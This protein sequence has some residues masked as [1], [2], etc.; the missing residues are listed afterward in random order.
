MPSGAS[1]EEMKTCFER[2][3]QVDKI[4]YSSRDTMWVTFKMY[5]SALRAM[6][7]LNKKPVPL[8]GFPTL[9]GHQFKLSLNDI[10]RRE[11]LDKGLPTSATELNRRTSGTAPQSQPPE[12]GTGGRPGGGHPNQRPSPL[13]PVPV[14]KHRTSIQQPGKAASSVR[15]QGGAPMGAGAKSTAVTRTPPNVSRSPQVPPSRKTATPPPPPKSTAPPPPSQPPP[16]NSARVGTTASK[17]A[18]ASRQQPKTQ[19]A[20]KAVPSSKQQPKSQEASQV[21]PSPLQQPKKQEASEGDLQTGRRVTLRLQ[22]K[23]KEKVTA[24]AEEGVTTEAS[25]SAVSPKASPAD[26]SSNPNSSVAATLT[27]RGGVSSGIRSKAPPPCTQKKTLPE[28]AQTTQCLQGN[29]TEPKQPKPVL[30][31]RPVVSVSPETQKSP[32]MGRGPHSFNPILVQTSQILTSS[33]TRHPSK[34]ANSTSGGVNGAAASSDR[35]DG[36]E[37]AALHTR[38]RGE[39][40][41]SPQGSLV[42]SQKEGGK[43]PRQETASSQEEAKRQRQSN[44]SQ[45]N[46]TKTVPS[47]GKHSRDHLQRGPQAPEPPPKRLRTTLSPV[48]EPDPQHKPPSLPEFESRTLVPP[49]VAP[50]G[51]VVL[52]VKPSASSAPLP[53]SQS[54][55]VPERSTS[56]ATAAASRSADLAGA[57][58][59]HRRDG[60][61]VPPPPPPEP[62]LRPRHQK[63]QGQLVGGESAQRGKA[64][65]PRVGPPPYDAVSGVAS[66]L[67]QSDAPA[68]AGASLGPA[69]MNSRKLSSSQLKTSSRPE[70]TSGKQVQ[71]PASSSESI[72]SSSST[73]L[74]GGLQLH[75]MRRPA[76]FAPIDLLFNGTL[77]LR[78]N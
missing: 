55:S 30:K 34:A 65:N 53:S 72:I 63:R 42:S 52:S 74:P 8:D 69:A 24:A 51:P 46:T 70:G 56:S 36:R 44:E 39:C 19:E 27:H 64:R 21:A 33:S 48:S 40:I 22:K 68:A 43:G 9:G 73:V 77:P 47:N 62:P 25:T 20:P 41:D 18:P 10:S 50:P 38:G 37:G 5:T 13:A 15:R 57:P 23:P 71:L 17:S 11:L 14:P 28:S 1:A 29:Q 78:Q 75:F 59:T 4:S 7:D 67:P 26:R 12:R 54:A 49:P 16:N 60:S 6:E 58:G 35:L 32:P 31:P 61:G 66:L 45:S 3:G 2:Y 76:S